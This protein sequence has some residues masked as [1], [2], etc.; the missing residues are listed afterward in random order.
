MNV[1]QKKKNSKILKSL[2]DSVGFDL[3]YF[4]W[5]LLYTA[6]YFRIWTPTF[7]WVL[8]DCIFSVRNDAGDYLTYYHELP[9]CQNI[10]LSVSYAHDIFAI[11][12]PA[13]RICMMLSYVDVKYV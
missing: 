12:H 1:T 10:R 13:R 3:F 9:N 11:M 6:R 2:L 8:Q 5:F 7:C 4:A